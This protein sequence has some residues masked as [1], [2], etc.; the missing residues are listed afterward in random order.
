[1]GSDVGHER[2]DAA[3]REHGR[4]AVAGLLQDRDEAREPE[5]A[6]LCES[7]LVGVLDAPGPKREG[8]PR[9]GEEDE[10]AAVPARDHEVAV[11]DDA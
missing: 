9:A 2:L 7:P 10:G 6:H 11:E 1:M 8:E 4:C 5:P 3:L